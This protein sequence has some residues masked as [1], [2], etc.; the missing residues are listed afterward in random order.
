MNREI[1]FRGQ[2][3]DTKE[4]V[5]GFYYKGHRYNTGVPL[6]DCRMFSTIITPEAEMYD[7]IPESVGQYTGL[8]DIH[9]NEIWEDDIVTN[10]SGNRWWI[11][12]WEDGGTW[13]TRNRT[14]D[15]PGGV[16][17]SKASIHF[18]NTV[19]VGNVFDTPD[20]LVRPE[21]RQ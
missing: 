20:E 6:G 5:Y 19:V 11:K 17:I 10:A 7:V 4:W 18:E 16:C 2:R 13:I 12:F 3:T 1:K 9:G 15:L 8:K 21:K 14:S